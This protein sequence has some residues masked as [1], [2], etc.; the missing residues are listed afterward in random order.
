MP[1]G[2]HYLADLPAAMICVAATIVVV[3][4][5]HGALATYAAAERSTL[6]PLQGVIG[7]GGSP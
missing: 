7:E 6:S 4:R 2:W 1:L 3:R 5:I